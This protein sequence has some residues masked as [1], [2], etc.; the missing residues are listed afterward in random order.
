MNQTDQQYQRMIEGVNAM[1]AR[2]GQMVTFRAARN[3]L[4][5][6]MPVELVAKANGTGVNADIAL[7]QLAGLL[8]PQL[9]MVRPSIMQSALGDN[10]TGN[11][12][13]YLT[14]VK[15]AVNE[16]MNSDEF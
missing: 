1:Q 16:L 12:G 10:Y 6:D 15:M 4:A 8:V 11:R 2:Y 3:C 5:I 7:Q 14:L 9:D 13:D